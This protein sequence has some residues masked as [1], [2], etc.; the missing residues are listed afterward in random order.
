[1]SADFRY[2]LKFVLDDV[3]AAEASHWLYF[4]TTARSVY[5]DRCV[6]SLYFDDVEFSSV[7]DNALLWIGT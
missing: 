1:M 3:R 5:P 6:H 4:H 2:E 7:R